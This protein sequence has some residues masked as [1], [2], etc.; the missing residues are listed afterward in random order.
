MQTLIEKARKF[1][2]SLVLPEGQDPR[3]MRAADLILSQGIARKVV[4]LASPAE[5]AEALQK[6]GVASPAF[7]ILDPAALPYLDELAQ[8][9]F[10]KREK[11]G[12]TLEAARETMKKRLYVGAMMVA[13]DKVDGMV[14]GSIA[15]TADMLRAAFQ[16]IGTAPGI[17]TASSCFWMKL[18]TPAPAGDD[19]L[20]FAD[21]GVNPCP[22]AE[23]LADIALATARTHAALVG[24]QARVALLSFSTR[25]SAKHDLVAKVQEAAKLAKEKFAAATDLDAV[26]DG[27]L[28]ADA[29]LVPAVAAQKAPDSAIAGRANVLVFPD[30][31]A[32]NI[33]YKLVERLARATALGPILQGVAKPMNDL[34]RGCKAE[35]I[36]GV[37][38]V[39]MCQ[40]AALRGSS[41]AAPAAP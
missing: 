25:A 20:I 19:V 37:A 1:S 33:A 34:S 36:A 35:D 40:A 13:C 3:V 4:V 22:T 23:Q 12:V 16:C 17:A 28:Q 27:E 31:Q 6:A 24:G 7:D 11:K 38:A 15:S 18:A 29:A 32:G 14:A 8:A 2:G 26:L 39:T 41:A 10:K 5:A 9:F 21:C 30:L